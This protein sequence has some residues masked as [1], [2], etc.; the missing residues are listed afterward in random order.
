MHVPYS[1]E[2]RRRRMGRLQRRD[3]H[4]ILDQR[5]M[6]RSRRGTQGAL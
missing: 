6:C 1:R 4:G 3:T 5:R 2:P